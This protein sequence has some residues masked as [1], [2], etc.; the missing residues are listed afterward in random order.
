LEEPPNAEINATQSK[1]KFPKRGC[2]TF[3]ER[4]HCIDNN[5]CLYCGKPGHKAIECKAPPNKQPGTKL[6]Q[7]DMI[8][9]EEIGN[10]DLLDESGVNQMSTNQYMPLI[11]TN[12][13]MESTMDTSF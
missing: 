10:T 11:D 13:V 1:G 7:V 6:C 12:D 3:A 9:E 2:L 8:P 4:K 5:L